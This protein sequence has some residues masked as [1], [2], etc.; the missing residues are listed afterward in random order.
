VAEV[1]CS[2]C[3][4]KE[5]AKKLNLSLNTVKLYLRNVYRKVGVSSKVLLLLRFLEDVSVCDLLLLR[6]RL[7]TEMDSLCRTEKPTLR[8]EVGPNR[9]SRPFRFLNE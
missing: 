2:G 5:T 9:G 1:V 8:G 3:S 6:G 7:K 4:N